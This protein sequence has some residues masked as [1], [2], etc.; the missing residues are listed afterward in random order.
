MALALGDF[1]FRAV[2]PA[3][4]YDKNDFSDPY[5]ASWL[6]LHGQNPY[7]VGLA[8]RINHDLA[9]TDA[10]IVPVYPATAYVL[11]SPL[12]LL[13]WRF[14]NLLWALLGV[15]AVSLMACLL[16]RIAGFSFGEDRA[17]FL[18]ACVF[19]AAP[20]HTSLH[21]ANSAA[22]AIG[23]CVLAIYFAG[24]DM[25]AWAG[26][27]LALAVCLKPQL[28][29]WIFVFYL[30]RLRW[31]VVL[32]A[33]AL[34]AIVAAVALLR[35]PMSMLALMHNYGA[36][37]HYWFRPGGMNDFSAA[38]P[39]RFELLNA[40]VALAPLL[41][42]AVA[43]NVAAW[44]LFAAGIGIWL[45]A[46]LRRPFCDDL[47]AISSLMALALIPVYH[48]SYDGGIVLLALG[49]LLQRHSEQLRSI[50]GA[51]AFAIFALLAPGELAI[52]FLTLHLPTSVLN[53][54]WWNRMIAAYAPWMV[55]LLNGF[56]LDALAMM[57]V[58]SGDGVRD[59][60]NGTGT[61]SI[62]HSHM[63]EAECKG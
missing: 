25:N 2:I 3:Y 59:R 56:L 41:S 10:K 18:A 48:R 43:A 62:A 50:S 13:P 31:R 7:D 29:I 21:V 63:C 20:L 26:T 6:W 8:T 42:S 60:L 4:A 16:P 53:G 44:V 52:R 47:L 37:L 1:A 22:I 19:C 35:I 33:A 12:S 14:A 32:P 34:G 40:Q 38:N 46:V 58:K 11:V 57:Q 51:V 23:L 45:W 55:L 39:F 28:G 27:I 30:V 15:T 36:N 24:R 9:H 5:C 49:W 61:A 17:W 54:W